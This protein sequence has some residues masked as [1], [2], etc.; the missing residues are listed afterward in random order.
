MAASDGWDASLGQVTNTCKSCGKRN[1]VPPEHLADRGKCGSC[2]TAF[3]PLSSPLDFDHIVQGARAPV[4]VDFWAAWCGP[5]RMAAPEVER[6]A[7]EGAGR[8]VTLKVDTEKHGG[9]AAR[10]NVR[11]IPNFIVFKGAKVAKQQAGLVNSRALLEIVES[12]ERAA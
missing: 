9:L 3:G 10:Y 12:I 8:M 7:K 11:G 4:L 2:A 6:A 5:C 1:R